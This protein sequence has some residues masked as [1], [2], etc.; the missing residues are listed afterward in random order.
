MMILLLLAALGHAYLW[1]A[2]VNRSHAV[3]WSQRLVHALTLAM[4]VLAA[5]IPVAMGWTVYREVMERGGGNLFT[6]PWP[7]MGYLAACWVGGVWALGQW[8]GRLALDLR[9]PHARSR[10]RVRRLKPPADATSNLDPPEAGSVPFQGAAPRLQEASFVARLP[11]NE[12]LSLEEVEHRV[13][14]TGL[15]RRLSGLTI[16]HLSDVHMTGLIGS[17]YFAEVV[18]RCNRREPDLVAITG[19]LV[20][21]E[22]CI[23]WIPETLGRLRARWGVYF[24]LGNHDRRVD[25]Q[26]LRTVM[27]KQGFVDLGGRVVEL[28]LR[29]ARLVLAG[30]EVP[31]F[32]PAADF[33]GAPAVSGKGGPPR[34]A[35][36]HSPDQLSWAR[37]HEVDLL[38]VGHT[39]GGQ[40]CL[41]LIGPILCPC[42]HGVR[43]TR[44]I[45][46]NPPTV[47]H[48]SKGLSA[49]IPIRFG[50]LPEIVTLT[51]HPR[52]DPG[53]AANVFAS[54][55]A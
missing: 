6:L 10:S 37:R 23:D 54:G 27:V 55:P 46:A 17:W 7:A 35:L 47:M 14:L 48:V 18:R 34:I 22:A 42:V 11:L 16:L 52:L 49:E 32:S 4:F 13:E 25:S 26:R 28:H 8:V 50:A 20:D 53:D 2:L 30:N 44:G 45:Y 21:E 24:I 3:G 31:W 43:Y 19:D 40:V 33:H 39:H 29:G 41:P 12:S 51:L 36:A 38:L 9:R 15:P 1:V 5:G